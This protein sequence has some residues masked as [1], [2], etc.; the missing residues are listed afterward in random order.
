MCNKKT[1]A[2]IGQINVQLL[3]DNGPDKNSTSETIWKREKQRGNVWLKAHLTLEPST[4]RLRY[5]I[6]IEGVVG[7]G[8]QSG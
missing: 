6:V 5:Y 4:S 3:A 2:K 8:S 7:K 1:F